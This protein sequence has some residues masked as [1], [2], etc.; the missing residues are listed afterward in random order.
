M[1]LKTKQLISILKISWVMI[2]IF[3]NFNLVFGQDNDSLEDASISLS[4][5]EDPESNKIVATATD[6]NGEPIE[7]LDLYFYVKRTFSNLP[8]GDVFNTTDENGMVEVEFPNDLP[9]DN[10]G[11]VTIL[12]KIKESDLYNDLTIETTKKWGIPT[13]QF[14]QLEEKRSLWAAAANAP[15][16]LVI[17]IST[18]IISIWFINCYI[19][20]ILFRISK[21]K[22]QKR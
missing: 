7:E 20:Y 18:M 2:F 15:I 3:S 10:K 4:F 9:G 17:S 19:L 22:S 13:E 8:I 16:V 14:D 5:V 21:I 11:N 12:V 6:N 1:K